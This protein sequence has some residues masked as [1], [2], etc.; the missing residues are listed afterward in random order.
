MK[1]GIEV[2]TNDWCNKKGNL[3]YSPKKFQVNNSNVY[4]KLCHHGYKFTL[5]NG[6]YKATNFLQHIFLKHSPSKS[7]IAGFISLFGHTFIYLISILKTSIA[8]RLDKLFEATKRSSERTSAGAAA[9]VT[10]S[11]FVN[12]SDSKGIVRLVL[13]KDCLQ[14]SRKQDF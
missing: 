12:I 5:V 13:K 10:P 1:K 7:G 14:V 4:C 3:M 8:S 11:A 9:T 2:H 6:Y